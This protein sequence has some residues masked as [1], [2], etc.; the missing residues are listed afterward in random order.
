MPIKVICE[1]G[2]TYAVGEDKRGKRFR[3]KECGETCQVPAPKRKAAR[4]K[5]ELEYD[6]YDDY[7][8]DYD[9]YDDYDEPA[10]R[11]SSVKKKSSKGKSKSSKKKRKSSSDGPSPLKMI[12]GIISMVLGAG[13]MVFVGGAM[14]GAWGDGDAGRRPFKAIG[15]GLTLIGVGWYWFTGQGGDDE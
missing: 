11:R 9:E 6:E 10:P 13:I 14:F 4:P 1:C 5:P 8:D 12:G 3:C 7:G 15:F 2:K